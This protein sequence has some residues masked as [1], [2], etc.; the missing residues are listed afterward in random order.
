[1][2]Q[3]TKTLFS[4]GGLF[5]HDSFFFLFLALRTLSPHLFSSG[6]EFSS[7]GLRMTPAPVA[8]GPEA[9]S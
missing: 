8:G 6:T 4:G 5:F 7:G 9:F 2:F 3:G 1:M